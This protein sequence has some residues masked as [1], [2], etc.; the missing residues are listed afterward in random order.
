VVSAF[1]GA[2]YDSFVEPGDAKTAASN[3][4]DW[5][6]SVNMQERVNLVKEAF[7]IDTRL[8]HGT[9]IHVRLPFSTR[10]RAARAAGS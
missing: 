10:D 1:V 3:I 6:S 4:E 9:T 2:V 7:S 8:G 5:G